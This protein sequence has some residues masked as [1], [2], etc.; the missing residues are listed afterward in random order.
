MAWTRNASGSSW[1]WVAAICGYFAFQAW[2]RWA[3]GAGLGLDEAQILL[4]A[5]APAWGYGPQPPLYAWLQWAVFQS[6]VDP[7]LGLSVLKNALLATTYLAV[8]ALLQSAYPAHVAGLAAL[9]LMLLP[10]I[11]WESQR[12][13]THSVLA[14]T[15]GALIC[16][17]F[18]T[19]VLP[20]RRGGY[21]LFGLL[22]GLGLIAKVNFAAVPLALVIAAALMAEHRGKLRF[23]GLAVSVLVAAAVVAGPGLWMWRN[24]ER[25]FASAGKMEFAGADAAW[26]IVAGQG[27]AAVAV[28]AALFLALAL[29]V[30]AI[31]RRVGAKNARAVKAAPLERFL[32]RMV[33]IAV[34]VTA[35]V[36]VGSGATNV[37]DRW[38]QPALFMAGPLIALWLLRRASPRGVKALGAVIV[39]LAVFVIAALPFHML[40]GTGGGPP[41]MS[42][43]VGAIA[44]RIAAAHP[45]GAG[46]VADREWLAGSL[47]WRLPGR[48]VER[49]SL[50]GAEVLGP[51]GAVLVWMEGGPEEGAALAAILSVRW[52][53]ALET[54]AVEAFSAPYPHAPEERF[55]VHAMA[56]RVAGD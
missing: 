54:G 32:W 48:P 21:A 13:L 56:V 50:A 51:E 46:V 12:A 6:G 43:P 4:D 15:M 8:F 9:S 16:L 35:A 38:M 25:A 53:V 24:R 44:E 40:L 55:G 47:A 17:V 19:R 30:V 1:A 45:E 36:V 37:K 26:W 7:I 39:T 5:R 2:W 27:I 49:L 14:T 29:V 23:R 22:A 31:L 34:L 42:A 28:A 41:R 11:A 3:L 18:W 33:L 10:Q 52:G 20:G